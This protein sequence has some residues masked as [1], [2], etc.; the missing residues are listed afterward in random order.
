MAVNVTL[1]DCGSY[2]V[3]HADAPLTLEDV[4][5]LTAAYVALIESTG[6]KRILNDMRN[7]PSVLG[8]SEDFHFAYQDT[9]QQQLPID[10]R[11]AILIDLDDS[12][13]DF[14]KMVARNA[15]Y[16]VELFEDRDSA[17]DWLLMDF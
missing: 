5:A 14:Q 17:V 4:R 16:T 9:R 3:G 2:I 7:T 13:H 12:S 6:I 1:S 8:V 15:G 11:A 10:I